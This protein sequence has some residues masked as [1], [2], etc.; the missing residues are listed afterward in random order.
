MK[1]NITR[2]AAAEILR[3]T[4]AHRS[5][6]SSE[7]ARRWADPDAIESCLG[8]IGFKSDADEVTLDNAEN[9]IETFRVAVLAVE[10]G[11]AK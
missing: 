11:I 1:A 9:V 10:G 5:K 6:K 3:H 2:R 4:A 7:H 8:I